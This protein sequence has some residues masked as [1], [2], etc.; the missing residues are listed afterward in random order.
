MSETL[1]CIACPATMQNVMGEKGHQPI[2]GLSFHTHGHYGSAVFDP[3][4]GSYIQIAVCDACLTNAFERGIVR[5]SAPDPKSPY[6]IAYQSKRAARTLK[7][8][9]FVATKKEEGHGNG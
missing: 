7:R 1:H 3:M 8:S 9:G 2:D 4:D 6:S 5:Q